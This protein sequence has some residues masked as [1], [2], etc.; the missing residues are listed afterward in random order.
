MVDPFPQVVPSGQLRKSYISVPA[1][2]YHQSTGYAVAYFSKFGEYCY[3]IKKTTADTN[4]I[5]ITYI[6][7]H[8]AE[9]TINV[10]PRMR[11]FAFFQETYDELTQKV[12]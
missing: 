4:G 8:G 2:V 9:K 11:V 10:N 6:D 1:G 12:G 7:E 3:R 5:N